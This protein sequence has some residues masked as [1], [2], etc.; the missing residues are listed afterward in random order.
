MKRTLVVGVDGSTESRA[1]ADWAAEEAERRDMHV[2]LVHAWLWQPLAVPVVQD[3]GVEARRAQEILEETQAELTRHHPRLSL[4]AEVVPDVPV[5]A[6]LR[7]AKDAE[8]LVLGTR[9]HSALAG[10]LL[11]SYGQQLIA[12]TECPVVSVRARHGIAAPGPAEGEVVVGQQGGVEESA[13]VLRFAF[14]AAAARRSP[15]RAVR[16][17]SMPPVYGYSPGSLWIAD[18]L[19]GLEPYEKAALEQALEPWRVR[20]PEVDVI[21]HVEHG[22]AGHVLLSVASDAQ[23]LVVGRQIRDSALGTRTGS[24]AH[25][26]LHHSACPVAVVPHH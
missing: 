17:W 23:L 2:H 19:G 16:A 11:G 26:V 6:L 7:A 10:F 8:M 20:Y 21:A 13:D 15:L 9:G 1:A 25:A 4:T 14:E 22:S 12:S 24:V 3:R 18:Q 5:P